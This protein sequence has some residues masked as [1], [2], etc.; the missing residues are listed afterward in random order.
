ME[1]TTTDKCI[2]YGCS[3]HKCQGTFVGDICGPCYD[4]I[5][6]GIV[7]P[8]DSFLGTWKSVATDLWTIMDDIDTLYDVY[9]FCDR[10]LLLRAIETAHYKRHKFAESID[11]FELEW[12]HEQR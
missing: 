12:K 1:L 11:G 4:I 10:G 7:G 3:N 5:T 8:T 9:K 6:K 2:V